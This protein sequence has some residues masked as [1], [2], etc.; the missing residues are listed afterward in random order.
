MV[1][2]PENFFLRMGSGAA[3]KYQP[4]CLN[5]CFPK[6]HS[7]NSICIFVTFFCILAQRIFI[8]AF[9]FICFLLSILNHKSKGNCI[10]NQMFKCKNTRYNCIFSTFSL[11]NAFLN[12]KLFIWCNI[13][14]IWSVIKFGLL[15]LKFTFGLYGGGGR[16]LASKLEGSKVPPPHDHKRP[17]EAQRGKNTSQHGAL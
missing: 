10:S 8:D 17:Y 16:G 4:L 15:K 14:A 3:H 7:C 13:F 11:W 1:N 6:M 2:F 12:V 9:Y 5:K